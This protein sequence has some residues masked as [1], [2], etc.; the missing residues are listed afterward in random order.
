MKT[1]FSSIEKKFPV[2]IFARKMSVNTRTVGVGVKFNAACNLSL[3]E[4][5]PRKN[6]KGWT[7]EGKKD[8]FQIRGGSVVARLGPSGRGSTRWI[9]IWDTRRRGMGRR[10]RNHPSHVRPRI[11]FRDN[12]VARDRKLCQVTE[13]PGEKRRETKNVRE[14]RK[15]LDR[16]G[17]GEME[18]RAC[19]RACVLYGRVAQKTSLVHRG[20]GIVNRNRATVC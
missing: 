5:S 7:S 11:R 17:D 1:L 8:A 16:R 9:L 2:Y 18:R 13:S 4:S 15:K 3:A 12:G 19:V 20:N 6:V 14:K 10:A